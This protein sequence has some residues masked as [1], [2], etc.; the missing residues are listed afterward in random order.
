MAKRSLKSINVF[1]KTIKCIV[2]S[3]K[4]FSSNDFSCNT[5]YNR[6][7]KPA[8]DILMSESYVKECLYEK[9]FVRKEN[10]DIQFYFISSQYDD[11]D[12][13]IGRKKK[14][15]RL[16]LFRSYS[17]KHRLKHS[18]WKCTKDKWTCTTICFDDSCCWWWYSRC[19]YW[20]QLNTRYF[21]SRLVPINIYIERMPVLFMKIWSL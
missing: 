16:L 19:E 18:F 5:M 12:Q 11:N 13:A 20:T 8:D 6:F 15:T 10:A 9:V 4:A 7:M 21:T 3:A 14:P 1:H 17:I 2:H